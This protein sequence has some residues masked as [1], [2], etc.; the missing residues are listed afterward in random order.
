LQAHGLDGRSAPHGSIEDMASA[1]LKE[2]LVTQPEGPYLLGGHSSGSWVAFEMARQLRERGHEVAMVAVVDTPAPIPET[3]TVDVDEDEARFLSKIARLIERWAGQ[4][5]GVSYE[6][7]Q[8]LTRQER[9]DYLQE[10]LKT[11]DILPPQAG[12][13]QVRGLLQVFEAST[14]NCMQYH[15][16]G[17]YDGP[18]LLLRAADLHVEDEGIQIN[19]VEDDE[20]WGWRQLA[21][22]VKVCLVPGDHVT[23]MAEPHVRH[24][25]EE[26]ANGMQVVEMELQSHV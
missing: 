16:Q 9:M 2:M 11:T 19:P 4:D 6:E 21:R 13:D 3:R 20:T 23:M 10:R 8:S 5:L 15:P 14:R 26:L 25:A 22:Q 7:L 12:R 18:I 17:D 1:Y 24:L